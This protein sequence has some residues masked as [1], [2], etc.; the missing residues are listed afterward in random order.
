MSKPLLF[1]YL[2][3]ASVLTGC[4]EKP[5]GRVVIEPVAVK[6][7]N[8]A[9]EAISIPV[10]SSGILVSSEE[11]RLS[12]KTGGIVERILT[13]EGD[14]IKKGQL[15]ARLNMSEI[16]AQVSLAVTG[17][18]KALRDYNRAKNLHAD[19]VVT[20][21]QLQNASS[22]LSAAKSNLDIARF[23]QSHSEIKAPDNGIV[24]RQLVKVN[25][26][27]SPGYP[28]FL[29]GTTGRHWKVKTG[30]SDRDIVKVSPGDSASV[31]LDAWPGIKFPAVVEQL[32]EMANPMTGT[33]DAELLMKDSGYRMAAGFIASVDIYPSVKDTFV[34]VPVGSVVEADGQAGYIFSITD[35]M[36]ARK[37]KVG[38]ITVSGD[39][40]AIKTGIE[41]IGLIV[42]EGAAYLRDGDK[43][44]IVK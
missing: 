33:Y 14:R 36:T 16:N 28:V 11:M 9:K 2:L 7:G 38:I 31:I 26:L 34:L 21:E 32:G 40:T 15:L 13:R 4:R 29:F 42:T 23:N 8:A 37:I 5:A 24:L 41:E 17:Y 1:F 18:D 44:K 39:R 22:A 3:L 25:E 27:V 19:S 10:H 6:A 30:L 20:L 43:I 35:S 12:F